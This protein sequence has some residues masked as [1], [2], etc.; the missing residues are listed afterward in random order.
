MAEARSWGVGKGF[1]AGGLRGER[2][3][4]LNSAFGVNSKDS[5]CV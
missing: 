3:L 2:L 4:T 1:R 5:M